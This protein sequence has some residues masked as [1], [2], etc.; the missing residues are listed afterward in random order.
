MP[1]HQE[2]SMAPGARG[3][4]VTYLSDGADVTAYLSQP[5]APGP[6]PGVLLIQPVHGL[7]PFLQTLADRLA[8]AGYVALAPAL[9]SRL[10]TIT[11]DPSGPPTDAAW[12]LTHQTPDPQ[13]ALDLQNALSYLAQLPS[14]GDGRLGAIGFCAGGR[15]GLFLAA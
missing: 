6:H 9:Y 4:F 1:R 12:E 11:T 3:Q 5:T 10:G 8:V 7:I 15:Y 13:V 2:E 14:V